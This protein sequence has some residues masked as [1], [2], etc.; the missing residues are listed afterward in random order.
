VDLIFTARVRPGR[1]RGQR[2]GLP[3]I[4]LDAID[5]DIPYGVYRVKMQAGQQSQNGILHYGRKETFREGTSME[6]IVKD[7]VPNIT[8]KKVKIQI[9]Q[10]IRN[11]IKFKDTEKLKE[12]IKKDIRFLDSEYD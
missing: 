10:F 3:T 4:N 7:Y 2:M 5:L 11:V 9:S 12:Q 8:D 6:L 1:G